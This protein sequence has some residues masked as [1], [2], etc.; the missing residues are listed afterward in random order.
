MST[1]RFDA[2]QKNSLECDGAYGPF[3]KDLWVWVDRLDRRSRTQCTLR[4]WSKET[5][6]PREFVCNIQ[7]IWNE[8]DRADVH[9]APM[10]LRCL[11]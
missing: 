2:R 10:E 4:V 9:A 3:D 6:E 11:L 5:V 7:S 8:V 1:E